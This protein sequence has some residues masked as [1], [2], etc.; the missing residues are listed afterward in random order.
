LSPI[1]TVSE[2]AQS[3]LPTISVD[4]FG[5]ASVSTAGMERGEFGDGA[6]R[7]EED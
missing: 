6:S 1:R 4:L 5:P 3:Y 7:G 2:C